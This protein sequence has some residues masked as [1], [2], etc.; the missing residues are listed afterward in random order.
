MNTEEEKIDLNQPALKRPMDKSQMGQEV[1][2]LNVLLGMLNDPNVTGAEVPAEEKMKA[3]AKR[4][5]LMERLAESKQVTQ[6]EEQPETPVEI[7]APAASVPTAATPRG[8]KRHPKIFLT[9]RLKA[10]KD[11]VA[12]AGGYTIYGFSDPL[13]YLATH[14]TG[15]PVTANQNKDLPGMRA[16][17]QTVGQ[18]GRNIINEQYPIT[19]ARVLFVTMIRSLHAAK[20]IDGYGVNWANFGA[21]ENLWLDALLNRYAETPAITAA[22]T[23]VR[24]ENEFKRLQSEG[25]QHWHVITSP[26]AWAKRLALDKMTPASPQLKDTSEKLAADLDA[27]VT[28]QISASRNGPKLRCVWNDPDSPPPSSRLH[29]LQEF[30]AASV[31]AQQTQQ[32]VVTGE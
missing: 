32:S 18:W 1:G 26:S 31:E 23:N 5:T 19:P 30:L 4:K 15:I 17:L 7:A 22:V 27:Q 20:I 24:F 8:F 11:Y 21:D 25:W 13:N 9:G 10:G 28:K 29:T 12:S 2:A 16:F 3:K 14:F 6:Q